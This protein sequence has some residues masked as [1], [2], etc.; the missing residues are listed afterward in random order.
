MNTLE[1][2]REQ[3]QQDIVSYL[4]GFDPTTVEYLCQ[5]VV[6]RCNELQHNQQQVAHLNQIS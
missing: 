4:D 2:L 5:M 3:L 6:D 1:E